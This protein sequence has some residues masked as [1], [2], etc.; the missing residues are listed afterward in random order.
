MRSWERCCI[1]LPE[2]GSGKLQLKDRVGTVCFALRSDN[3]CWWSRN[4]EGH[5]LNAGTWPSL[6][7]MSL[8]HARHIGRMT[9]A[10][11]I[12]KSEHLVL[13]QDGAFLAGFADHQADG[14]QED[15]NNLSA[16]GRDLL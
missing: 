16:F 11:L 9:H 1:E 8:H 5:S 15:T 10:F 7:L 4:G 6:K 12:V 14:S 13:Y 2:V 3:S